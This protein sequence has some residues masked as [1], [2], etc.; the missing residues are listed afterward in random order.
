MSGLT[1][2]LVR[3]VRQLLV[4]TED[5]RVA[6][7]FVLDTMG[8]YVAGGVTPQGTILRDYIQGEG[9]SADDLEKRVFLTA[10]L[11]HITETDDLHRD[12]V[13][14]P[15]C[16][17]VPVA[18]ELARTL[19]RS[20]ADAL[21]AV[22][23]GYEVMLRIGEA[24]GSEHYKVFHNTATA[25]VFGAAAAAAQL[26]ELDEDQW[27]W[28]MGNAGTQAAGLWQ[29]NADA[30]MSKH[31]HA[32]HA[33]QSGLRAALLAS[34]GFTG[35]EHILEG[36]KGF[37]R[38]FCP[39]PDPGRVLVSAAG[40]K[41]GETSVKPYPSCRHTHPAID[42]ALHLRAQLQREGV[43]VRQI[44]HVHIHTYSTAVRVTDNATPDTTFAAKFSIQYCVAT[45]L[46]RGFPVLEHFEEEKLT[47][48]ASHR[49]LG[50]TSVDTS[51]D[52]EARYPQAWGSGITLELKQG[53][54]LEYSTF[55]A[56]GDP[57]KPVTESELKHKILGEFTWA[58]LSPAQAES[59]FADFDQLPGADTVPH[60]WWNT[61]DDQ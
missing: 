27:V 13:T 24:L 51:P 49:L 38:G 47:V 37:F 12:S 5:L 8:S 60:L 17:V 36:D 19:G 6:R 39:N 41:I 15:G 23:A 20:G 10:A 28:A 1:R 4:S 58:G 42:C 40:W 18:L 3:L 25:G 59:Y 43:D 44:S 55:S 7:Y 33:A 22:L 46:D 30:T 35:P 52:F 56:K 34:H 14:H 26:L 11:S 31:L 57:E 2:N 61:S 48:M 21:H 45:A 54:R 29:F 50:S 16:V 9:S 53:R 32:G